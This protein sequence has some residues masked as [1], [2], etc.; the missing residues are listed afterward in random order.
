MTSTIIKNVTLAGGGVLGS[1]IAM[2]T[3]FFGFNVTIYDKEPE[4]VKERINKL[5]KTYS[6]FFKKDQAETQAI[7]DKIQ[8]QPELASAVKDANLVIEALPEV[9]DIKNSFYQELSKVAPQDTIFASN[10]STLV[11]SQMV[12]AT[13]RPDKF[14][15]L[16]FANSIWARN[17]AEIMGSPKTDPAIFDT[18]VQFAKDINMVALP[19]HKEQAGYIL[20]TLLVPFLDSAMYLYANDIA[21]PQSIDKTWMVA[22]GAPMGPFAIMDTVGINTIMN[23]N[24]EKAKGG[25][26]TA[27]KVMAKLQA[28]LIDKGRMGLE[29]GKGFYDYPNP[30]YKDPS[31]LT[32]KD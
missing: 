10:S 2:Q 21:D 11:P 8:Y 29:T 1:Q 13:G 31:F 14:L 6:D 25:S 26:Q 24:R 27:D 22:T 7:A 3:A 12:D 5:V 30:A 16:H 9:L 17:T 18:V 19:L 15:A 20:N 28:D 23:I 32:N 4:K